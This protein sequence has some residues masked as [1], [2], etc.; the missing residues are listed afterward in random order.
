MIP[1]RTGQVAIG[2]GR[3]QFISALGGATVAWPLAARAQQSMPLVGFIHGGAAIAFAGRIAAFR[4]GLGEEGYVES[5]NVLIEYHWLEGHFELLPTVLADLIRRRVAVI[6]TP[7]STPASIAAKAATATIPIVFG[8]GED[9]V[10]LGIVASLAHPGGNATGINFF[11][12]EIDAKRLGLMHD[13]LPKATR[14][15]VLVN[16]AD[17]T[18]ADTTSKTLKEAAH[19]LGLNIHFFSASTPA[20][21]DAVFTAIAR[22]QS[23]ALFIAAEGFFASRASQFAALAARDRLPASF[24]TSEGVKAGLLMSYGVDIADTFRQ[25]G[26]YVGRILKGETAADLPVQQPTRFDFAINMTTVKALG[27]EISPMLLARADEVIE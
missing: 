20:E 18:S 7:G 27:L 24:A 6:A 26:N 9:P 2:I 8:V 1:M 3:R 13:L 17:A 12:N 5:Q 25:V 10:A 23:D 16:P 15:A 4:A 21:I 14:F 22:D 11:V 19:T